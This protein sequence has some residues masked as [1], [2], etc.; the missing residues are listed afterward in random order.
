[1]AREAFR[2]FVPATGS[3]P[4]EKVGIRRSGRL[5]GDRRLAFVR[6]AEAEQ[7][8]TLLQEMQQYIGLR[9]HLRQLGHYQVMGREII[10]REPAN[11]CLA[12]AT[13]NDLDA[14]MIGTSLPD[15]SPEIMGKGNIIKIQQV[16][17]TFAFSK[18][19][20]KRQQDVYE[21]WHEVKSIHESNRRKGVVLELSSSELEATIWLLEMVGVDSTSLKINPE[22]YSYTLASLLWKMR[23]SVGETYEH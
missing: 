1:M 6:R 20:R 9:Q 12:D 13:H 7:P 16:F 8:R 15:N 22:G 10:G 19:S 14:I 11:I 23:T 17:D 2:S 18:F 3:V 5:P 4:I 21:R